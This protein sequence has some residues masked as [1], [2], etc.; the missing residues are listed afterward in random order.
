MSNDTDTRVV[1]ASVRRATSAQS[2]P[3]SP[4]V[5]TVDWNAV[6]S[7]SHGTYNL[8]TNEYTA[9]VA[10]TYEFTGSVMFGSDPSNFRAIV[11]LVKNG[12]NIKTSYIMGV[13]NIASGGSFAF[14]D[15][16]VAGDKYKIDIRPTV[17][18][19]LLSDA[20]EFGGSTWNIKRLSGPSA[21]AATE[22]IIARY[23][24]GGHYPN[25]SQNTASVIDYRGKVI[26]THNA[27]TVA[28][29]QP[30]TMQA[31]NSPGHW[32]FTAPVAGYYR[33]T[34]AIRFNNSAPW[35]VQDYQSL[36]LYKAPVGGT[37]AS[38][39]VLNETFAETAFTGTNINFFVHGSDVI[40]LL[41]GERIAVTITTNS[42]S[43]PAV[44]SSAGHHHIIIEKINR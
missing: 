24:L 3:A 34:A 36:S 23:D 21:I 37:F 19:S 35:S 7:D 41:A 2:L 25:V 10:G 5:T 28:T 32:Y 8:T 33:V 9:P 38:Y 31:I 15:K 13:A 17:G 14:Q 29:T 20:T 18:L 40:Y 1:Q 6:N 43:L 22:Q 11:Y 30:P 44:L 26:D 4:A 16:A 42:A 12:S 27:V 39:S